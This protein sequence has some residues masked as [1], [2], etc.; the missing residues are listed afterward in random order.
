MGA[1]T[2]NVVWNDDLVAELIEQ[3]DR[4]NTDVGII[5]VGELITEEVDVAIRV[6]Q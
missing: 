4:S 5:V 3:L 1:T 6:I 2:C